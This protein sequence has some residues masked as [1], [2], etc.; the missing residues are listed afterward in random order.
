MNP[1][2]RHLRVV[3][4]EADAPPLDLD[5]QEE[6]MEGRELA[7]QEP[8]TPPAVKD[9]GA[10]EPLEPTSVWTPR[11]TIDVVV[12]PISRQL[13]VVRH[14]HGGV[15]NASAKATRAGVAYGAIGLGRAAGAWWRWVTAADQVLAS[16]PQ[17]VLA[18]RAR[19]RKLSLYTLA[20]GVLGD[21]GLWLFVDW[22]WWGAPAIL[23]AT[24]AT[25]GG[26]AEA[27]TRR[28]V[29]EGGTESDAERTIGT[30]PGSKTVRQ[31]LAAAGQ[32]GKADEIRIIGPVT[33]QE[34][35]WV[36]VA[37]LKQGVPAAKAIKRQPEI[38]ASFGVGLPQI[39]VDPVRGH[40]G[41]VTIW[42]ADEDPLSGDPIPSPLVTR[43]D[44]FD[45]W[46][47]KVHAGLDARGRPVKFSLIERSLLVGGEAGSGKSSADHNVLGAVALDPHQRMRLIDGKGGSDLLDYEPIAHRFLADPDPEKCLEILLELQEEMEDRYR[48][49][50]R[51]GQRKVT[52]DNW[53]DLGMPLEF[54]HID[55]IQRFST[56]EEFGKRIVK[57]SWD[58]VSRG[59]A[60][61]IHFSAATQRPAAEVVPTLLRDILSI[62]WALRCTTPQA[63]D[64][65]LGQG[66]AGRG[67][68]ASTIDSTQRG[69]GLLLAEG[70]MPLWLRS[71]FLSDND[72]EVIARRA[73]RLREEAGTLPVTDTHP[74]RLLLEACIAAFGDAEAIWTQDL[75]PRLAR[76]AVWAHLADDPAELARLL[77][78]YGV[79]PKG[80]KLDGTNRNGYRRSDL[81]EALD[82]LWR[83]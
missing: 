8:A 82:L 55:E 29:T 28:T 47:E 11:R 54:L 39:A 44:P 73:Y 49:L 80:Q 31:A 38:A 75:L 57:T 53:Q 24:T 19:R 36:A 67:Y 83:R 3:R 56:D 32:L 25:V 5:D 64:T 21:L 59:R 45:V 69:A 2:P 48:A 18:E 37:D 14:E 12:A 30:H 51:A 40:N 42:C 13:D 1:E 33:R 17:I 6:E 66:W 60:S 68:N 76:D 4:D 20:G 35:A 41:R 9:A 79:V 63:S 62:R 65:I 72:V 50:K 7:V 43:S 23:L 16:Q 77:R 26:V 52:A 70:A 71:C 22:P 58:L 46:R 61:A 10:A 15:L 34:H 78:P 81:V 74:G 27:L